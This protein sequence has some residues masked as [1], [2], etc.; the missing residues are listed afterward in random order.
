MTHTG[1]AARIY[2]TQLEEFGDTE[3]TG[4]HRAHGGSP[5]GLG[6]ESAVG[7]AFDAVLLLTE[8]CWGV[9]ALRATARKQLTEPDRTAACP[10]GA[11][12]ADLSAGRL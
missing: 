4:S 1:Q 11:E 9:C 5:G 10:D 8:H 12:N 7:M 3:V 6:V 2:C